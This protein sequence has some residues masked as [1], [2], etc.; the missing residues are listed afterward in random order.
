MPWLGS[1]RCLDDWLVDSTI[2]PCHRGLLLPTGV[3]WS[4]RQRRGVAVPRPHPG[5]AVS[6]CGMSHSLGWFSE[7]P[8]S[9][10]LS[11]LLPP[12]TFSCL[13]ILRIVVRYFCFSFG[14][15]LIRVGNVASISCTNNFSTR[16]ISSRLLYRVLKLIINFHSQLL[17]RVNNIMNIIN[18]KFLSDSQALNTNF[19]S[20]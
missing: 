3:T 5:P 1:S 8:V 6:P 20:V 9:G 4:V 19:S 2:S 16:T 13:F 10:N 18:S 14:N 11:Y 12:I 7:L 17:Q 15:E